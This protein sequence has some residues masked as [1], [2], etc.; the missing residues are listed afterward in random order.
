[1]AARTT[2]MQQKSEFKNTTNPKVTW[3]QPSAKVSP[4]QA[5]GACFILHGRVE[6]IIV[7]VSASTN[8]DAPWCKKHAHLVCSPT[9]VT[10][11]RCTAA[12]C[13]LSPTRK[14]KE[15]ATI[16]KIWKRRIFY[17]LW[18]AIRGMSSKIQLFCVC[19]S[20]ALSGGPRSLNISEAYWAG[21]SYM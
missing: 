16:E 4:R 1:M 13:S 21:Y 6:G 7:H 15:K 12:L 11:T 19:L 20:N 10:T 2:H 17:A 8:P 18:S 9:P 3:S 5:P 14:Q